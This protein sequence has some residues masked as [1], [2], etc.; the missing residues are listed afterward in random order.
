MKKCESA[1][2]VE[3]PLFIVGCYFGTVQDERM[4]GDELGRVIVKP[5]VM[6]VIAHATLTCLLSANS[7]QQPTKVNYP[8][9]R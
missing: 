5:L 8:F 3:A 1:Y 7:S 6:G 2:M 9:Y 4:T